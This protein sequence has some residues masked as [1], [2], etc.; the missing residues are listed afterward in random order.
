MV[1]RVVLW[2]R[3]HAPTH[4]LAIPVPRDGVPNRR[5]VDRECCICFEEFG[6]DLLPFAP[7][8]GHIACRSCLRTLKDQDAEDTIHC[9]QCRGKF[10]ELDLRRLEPPPAP[11]TRGCKANA[12]VLDCTLKDLVLGLLGFWVA[13]P[14]LLAMETVQQAL[15]LAAVALVAFR[16][17]GIHRMLFTKAFM[18]Y[19]AVWRRLFLVR[20]CPA[21]R[22]NHASS[23]GENEE[24]AQVVRCHHCSLQYCWTCG[25]DHEEDTLWCACCRGVYRLRHLEGTLFHYGCTALVSTILHG[26]I[27][28]IA[29]K[30]A[31][32]ISTV[33]RGIVSLS[34]D[35]V[36]TILDTTV[37]MNFLVLRYSLIAGMALWIL[38][39]CFSLLF[40]VVSWHIGAMFNKIRPGDASGEGGFSVVAR[41]DMQPMYLMLFGKDWPPPRDCR[42]KR[43]VHVVELFTYQCL[44]ALALFACHWCIVGGFGT[45]M[46]CALGMLL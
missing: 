16:R 19:A 43:G 46:D 27:R 4:W 34:Y 28:H 45:Y 22:C 40:L 30:Q 24:L 31:P 33:G 3:N 8:C 9:P 13:V 17:L 11:A 25:S 44:A 39:T 12:G 14:F 1:D 20:H 35:G 42:T 38:P 18:W 26:L 32:I 7:Q 41:A 5:F 15:L 37:S 23:C 10:S 6:P 2:I 21:P 36:S 29:A